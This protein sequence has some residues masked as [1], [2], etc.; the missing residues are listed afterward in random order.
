MYFLFCHSMCLLSVLSMLSSMLEVSEAYE[1]VALHKPAFQLHPY[2]RNNK[3]FDATNAVDGL[4]SDLS[5]TGGQCAVSAL[6][7]EI[8]TWWVNLGRLHVIHHI[9][10]YFKTNNGIW[11]FT[12][13]ATSTFLGFSIYVSNTTDRL[14]GKLCFK[15]NNFNTSTIPAVFNTICYVQG[16]YVIY[17]NERLK[18]V[19]YPSDYNSDAE[20]DLCEVEVYGCPV[21]TTHCDVFDTVECVCL[22]C[23]PGY[24]G[25]TCEGKF[26]TDVKKNNCTHA[27]QG[28]IGGLSVSILII[29]VLILYIVQTRISM[30]RNP[31][32]LNAIELRNGANSVNTL[33]AGSNYTVNSY[34]ELG[35]SRITDPYYTIQE[36]TGVV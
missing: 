20:N 3:T 5:W 32:I 15:D 36:M 30:R 9:T 34:T 11:D 31:P 4:K 8:A 25:D 33:D 27:L 19:T 22:A 14:Q 17:Y 2:D 29:V 26:S 12:N 10:V 16:Q 13:N 28:L 1:N 24:H 23:K 35:W 18:G 6:G 21:Q 7:K